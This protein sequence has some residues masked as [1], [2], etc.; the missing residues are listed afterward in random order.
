MEPYGSPMMIGGNQL[1]IGH[2]DYPLPFRFLRLNR[3]N[4]VYFFNACI[5]FATKVRS[6]SEP[7]GT[8]TLTA[9]PS[10]IPFISGIALA[11]NC[12]V[13]AGR[14]NIYRSGSA[15]SP[16]FGI[17]FIYYPLSRRVSVDSV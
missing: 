6:I 8:G 17:G 4:F 1:L 14:R 13:G 3:Q 7:I 11:G 12:R 10:K 16:I 9:T 2:L 15:S 5:S